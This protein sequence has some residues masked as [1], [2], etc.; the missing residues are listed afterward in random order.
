MPS[1]LEDIGGGDL[2]EAHLNRECARLS[3]LHGGDGA[4][5]GPFSRVLS[6]GVG[7]PEAGALLPAAHLGAAAW[8]TRSLQHTVAPQR[9][10]HRLHLIAPGRL[11]RRVQA[12]QKRQQ[13]PKFFTNGGPN[14]DLLLTLHLLRVARE[15]TWPRT[16]CIWSPEHR[17]LGAVN[18][19]R[20]N[21]RRQ[22]RLAE[23]IHCL[24][25]RNTNPNKAS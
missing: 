20:A 7:P 15:T 14:R 17:R 2:G 22:K 23:G 25:P 3:M 6:C 4:P 16:R 12:G 24:P 19:R 8:E 18:Q 21:A 1:A 9:R 13:S 10:V 5:Q 11:Q